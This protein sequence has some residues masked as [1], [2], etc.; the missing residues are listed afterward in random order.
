[1]VFSCYIKG[2]STRNTLVNSPPITPWQAVPH[3]HL[4]T[5]FKTLLHIS[6][7][8]MNCLTLIEHRSALKMQVK[9]SEIHIDAAYS[10]DLV[11]HT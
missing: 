6:L 5:L 3:S 4:M 7:N 2:A 1:M 8:I 11:T 9:T 10:S